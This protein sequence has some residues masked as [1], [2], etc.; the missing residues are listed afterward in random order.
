MLL[1]NNQDVKTTPTHASIH[2]KNNLR[3]RHSIQ[4]CGVLFKYP[5]NHLHVPLWV[6]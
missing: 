1:I 6:D 4:D 2:L 5:I 3:R